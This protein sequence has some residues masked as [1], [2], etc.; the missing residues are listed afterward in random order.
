MSRAVARLHRMSISEI[1]AGG[2]AVYT[3]RVLHVWSTLV[4]FECFDRKLTARMHGAILCKML[5]V[6]D[7]LRS[8]STPKIF[9]GDIARNIARIWHV[10]FTLV[11]F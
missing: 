6:I 8:V 5:R 1:I 2:I 10:W 3:A 9:A 4:S 7:K 11:T